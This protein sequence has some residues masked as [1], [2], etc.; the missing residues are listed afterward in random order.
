[1][2]DL[3][4]RAG[5]DDAAVAIERL[6][7]FGRVA[8]EAK[9]TVVVVLEDVSPTCLGP[10]EQRETTRQRQDAAS[11]ILMRRRHAD[12]THAADV[13]QLVDAQ[14]LLVDRDVPDICTGGPQAE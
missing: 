11:R 12:Q 10:I 1:E 4:G 5:V 7:A 13:V 3:R 14:A 8:R 2:E 6:E 9:L